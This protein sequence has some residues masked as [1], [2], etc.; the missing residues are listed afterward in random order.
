[1]M[2]LLKQ[3]ELCT[4]TIERRAPGNDERHCAKNKRTL[5]SAKIGRRQSMH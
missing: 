3:S 1:M 5:V 4:I 2:P